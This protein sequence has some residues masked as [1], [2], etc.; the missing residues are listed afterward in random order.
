MLIMHHA[1]TE[2]P[3]H[4]ATNRWVQIGSS[5]ATD[6]ERAMEEAL[7]QLLHGRELE[8]TSLVIAFA[9]PAYDL[10]LLASRLQQRL[11]AV[12]LVGCSTA[13]EL[14]VGRALRRG[15]VLWALGGSG[16]SVAVGVGQ[17]DASGLRQAARDAA[18]CIHAVEERPNRALVLLAD[19][20]CGDQMEVVRGA[21]EVAGSAVPLVG[22]C[23]GDDMAM[24]ATQQIFGGTV[25]QNAVVAVA[26]SSEGPIGIGVS[27][28]WQPVGD[29]ML[30]TESIG[31][32]VK[33][34][35]DQ[36]AL[37]VYLSTLDAPPEVSTNPE[38]FAA[39]AATHP[40]GIPRRD[41]VEIRYIAG[42]NF[43]QRSLTCIASLPQGG[44][45]VIMRGNSSSVLEASESACREACNALQGVAPIGLLLFDCVARRS[46][47]ENE[48][49]GSEMT[50]IGDVV[51]DA[52]LAGFYTYGEIARIQGAGGFHN[53]TLVAM[54][55][56]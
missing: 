27:H 54:A 11:G 51:G 26:L 17:G 14:C 5:V 47:L 20:L 28:G 36:P 3:S 18:A 23:A 6:T 24:L 22:G 43:E 9:S 37:D 55:L 10:S 34:I 45:T 46:V 33:S 7:T 39:F 44:T 31:V 35:D 8:D 25:I 49:A 53:Q 32:S 38:A 42:A 1:E 15:L 13:G 52:P 50:R 29:Q 30:V 19:G 16:L 56:A 2:A 4:Q 41:R 40:L 12:P 48:A 21:Y